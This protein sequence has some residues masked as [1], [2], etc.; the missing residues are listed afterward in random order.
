VKLHYSSPDRVNPTPDCL[1]TY[2]ITLCQSQANVNKAFITPSQ[3]HRQAAAGKVIFDLLYGV[4]SEA[5]HTSDVACAVVGNSHKFF[6]Y[7]LPFSVYYCEQVYPPGA[8]T[9]GSKAVVLNTKL[10]IVNNKCAA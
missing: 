1:E 2:S 4:F 5:A 6:I 10:K 9:T 3:I 8:E 7:Y